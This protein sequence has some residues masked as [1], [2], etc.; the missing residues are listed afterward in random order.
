[1]DDYKIY[2]LGDSALTIELGK[3]INALVNDRVIALS[4]QIKN[5]KIEGILDII[6]AYSSVSIIYDVV[7][8][9]S[10][11]SSAA[12]YIHEKIDLAFSNVNA[13]SL[14][15]NRKV[16][17]PVCYDTSF[18]I[19]LV[20]MALEKKMSVPDIVAAHTSKLYR[21]YLLGFLPGFPYMGEVD[22]RIATSRKKS[23]RTKI[24][25]GNVGIAGVQT[26]IYPFDSPGGWNIIGKTPLKMFDAQ[27][28]NPVFLQP[29]DEIIFKPITLEV[30]NSLEN[31][32]LTD[33]INET[34]PSTDNPK[35][36]THLVIQKSGIAD[37][38]QDLG[39]FGFQNL[40]INPNGAMDKIAAQTANFLVGNTADEVVLECHFP[41]STILFNHSTLIAISGA[42]FTATIDDVEIPINTPVFVNQGAT[43]HFKKWKVGARTYL[44]VKNG[45]AISKWLNSYSTN[46]IAKAGGLEGRN[47]KSGDRISCNDTYL[48]P[49]YESHKY[50]SLL[51]H[52]E[53]DN[54]YNFEDIEIIMG[55]DFESLT[56]E[57][58]INFLSTEFLIS[59][60]SDKMGYRLEGEA[61]KIK[62]GNPPLLSSAV[63]R[64]T[65]QLLPNGQIIILMSDHQTTGGY[66][67]IGNVTSAAFSSLAQLPPNKKIRFKIVSIE[68]AEEKIWHQ[69]K[70][71]QK[72]KTACQLKWIEYNN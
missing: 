32:R 21:V 37:S 3:T 58:K 54:L 35:L 43:L 60:R 25:S 7:K 56:D 40:G 52:V 17:I 34:L 13:S 67:K 62:N 31:Q 36:S 16:E 5:L 12:K 72:I 27:K 26:G 22:E 57:S 41:A 71:L 23:P 9:R 2:A 8:I 44:A 68:H 11:H 14:T 15:L 38:F 1:M 55:I 53:I 6:P 65:M 51:W 42:D 49:D 63:T 46:I 33:A 18:G 50:V 61:L 45:F 48:R 20:E 69:Q 10:K 28:E 47:L 19:D 66:P 59:S 70:Y 29:G 64:G 39:R 24:K 30:Y 4:T